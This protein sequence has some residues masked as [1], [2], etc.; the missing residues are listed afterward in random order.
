M[1]PNEVLETLVEE[2]HRDHVGLWEIVQAVRF[3]LGADGRAETRAMTLHL[4]RGLLGERG[5]QVGHPTPDGRHFV[6]WD[7]APAEAVR[8]IEQAWSALGREPNIGE[9]AWFTSPPTAL[10]QSPQTA[11][12]QPPAR[13]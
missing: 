1:T 5:M 2:C 8:R 3:D 9:V 6:A 7:L 10:N 12:D 13:G 4:V 11:T